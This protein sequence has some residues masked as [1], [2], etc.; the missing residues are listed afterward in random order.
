M[1]DSWLKRFDWPLLV[2]SGLLLL[3]GLAMQ[4]SS[5]LGTDEPYFHNQII[6][7]V[8][9]LVGA[10]VL[11]MTGYRTIWQFSPAWYGV[12][13]LLLV[14]V[15]VT[16]RISHGAE[17]WLSIGSFTLQPS[18]LAKLAIVMMMAWL[19]SRGWDRQWSMWRQFGIMAGTALPL[20]GLVVVQPDLGTA[21]VMAVA[22][23]ACVWLSPVEKRVLLTLVGLVVVVGVAAW[24]VMAPYQR[25][26][27]TT[28]LDP[29]ASPLGAGYNVLQSQIAV[30]SGQWLGQGWGRG[31]QSHLNFLPEHHTDFIFASLCEEFGLVGG[32]LVLGLFGVILWRGTIIAW[33][34]KERSTVIL[35]GGIVLTLLFQALVN[36]AM[37][38][39]LAP[40]TGIPLPLVSYGGSSLLTTVLSIAVL[41]SIALEQ[42]E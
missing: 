28:F 37:N 6:F 42:S 36:M 22:W 18:E 16:G 26:R 29:G 27:I 9:S 8:F 40:V 33:R 19:V 32:L 23:L 21:T 35:A 34:A 3:I 17:S 5:T 15:A 30:G 14:L 20:I 24:L 39:G 13:L 38:V 41:E 31:T 25:A 2:A 10:A 1:Y 7:A 12:I 4:A 11:L